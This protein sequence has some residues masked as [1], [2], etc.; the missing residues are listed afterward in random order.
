[1]V[2]LYAVELSRKAR[3]VFRIKHLIG[4]RVFSTTTGPVGDPPGSEPPIDLH[5][6]AG[7]IMRQLLFQRH[8]IGIQRGLL[9]TCLE[10]NP[11]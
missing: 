9:A 3:G 8:S 11:R 5:T 7:L 6:N 1:M 2:M 10:V 4:V